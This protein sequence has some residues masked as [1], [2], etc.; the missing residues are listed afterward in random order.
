[1]APRSTVHVASA[2]A[3]A[4]KKI[5]D[6]AGR[7]FLYD[8]ATNG[9][10]EILGS[11]DGDLKRLAVEA[12]AL[13]PHRL[14]FEDLRPARI[15]PR[16][17]EFVVTGACNLRC[18]Y[19]A[20]RERY[21]SPAG[22]ND[23]MGKETALQAVDFVAS[24]VDGGPLLLKFF[25]GEP[26][27]GIDVI[28]AIVAEIERRGIECEKLIATNGLLLDEDIIDFLAAKRFQTF[29]SLDGPGEV[30][31]AHRRDAKGC[32]TYQRVVDKVRLIQQRQPQFFRSQLVVNLVVAPDQ[33]GRYR[34]NRRHLISLGFAPD[35]IHPQDTAPTGAECT[36][37]KPTQLRRLRREKRA[38]RRAM[39][40]ELLSGETV[41]PKRCDESYCRFS[42][43]AIAFGCPSAATETQPDNLGITDCQSGAWQVLTFWPDGKVSACIEF[44]RREDLVFANVATSAIDID[45]LDALKAK[46]RKSVV[47]G[48]CRTCWAMRYCP[49]VGCYKV[50]AENGCSSNW[51][52]EPMCLAIRKDVE[53]RMTDFVVAKICK[54][55]ERR[56]QNEAE[57]DQH[58]GRTVCGTNGDR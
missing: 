56:L 57:E 43:P 11:R 15:V 35:Q 19:C 31:D 26:L 55:R 38:L 13:R 34:E 42:P 8:R 10:F 9:L 25:G 49:H 12:G 7:R 40:E 28:R 20:T 22:H 2:K 4:P 51:Q 29:I 17:V 16:T 41:Q 46:F 27:I 36:C 52:Q 39:I 53:Q 5:L 32:G 23:L 1:M 14:A 24:H 21:L 30:H 50:F 44:Q 45:K 54:S 18:D 58:D 3:A 48:R 6:V 33:A 47:E 37:Y